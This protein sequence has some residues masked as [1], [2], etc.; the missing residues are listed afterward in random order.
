MSSTTYESGGLLHAVSL[1]DPESLKPAV[2]AVLGK[3]HPRGQLAWEVCLPEAFQHSDDARLAVM[4][5]EWD[6]LRGRV[7]VDFRSEQASIELFGGKS[8]IVRGGCQTSI[9]VDNETQRP[10]DDWVSTCEYTDDDVHYLEIEQ[11]WS[12]GI[13]LQ[14][15]V[16]V[17]RDDRCVLLADRVLP[18]QV[19]RRQPDPGCIIRYRNRLPL[20]NQVQMDI[21]RD[22]REAFFSDGRRRGFVMPLSTC[23]W[24]V[25]PS[26]ADLMM[27]HDKYLLLSRRAR[28]VV[29]RTARGSRFSA[30]AV[31]R[32]QANLA[33]IDGRRRS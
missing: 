6:V 11:S 1:C 4:M 5:P 27:T 19:R 16:M 2:D 24:R 22:T 12:G 13:V 26:D 18:S 30:S 33:K 23:E 14:R 29:L 25:G 21:E 9:E 32:P 7:H 15:Q 8:T 31:S 10:I 3:R 28:T 20:G 17:V